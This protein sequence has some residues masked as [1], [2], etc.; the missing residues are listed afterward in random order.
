MLPLLA[1]AKP[2]IAK[3]FVGVEHAVALHA[4]FD[5]FNR[6][7]LVGFELGGQLK[8]FF[9]FK[10]LIVDVVDLLIEFVEVVFA[11]IGDICMAK[12]Q[13]RKSG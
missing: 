12:L 10:H 7:D 3:L 6:I 4:L 9:I 2:K 5:I 8:S 11:D 13:Q 1:A